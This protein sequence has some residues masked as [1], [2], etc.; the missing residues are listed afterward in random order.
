MHSIPADT[1]VLIPIRSFDDSKSRLTDALDLAQRGALSV[2]MAGRVVAAAG[3]LPVRIVTDDPGVVE[4]AQRRR[5]GVLTV[6]VRGLNASVTAA[7]ARAASLGFERAI[8]AHA[9]L[10]AAVD[11]SVVDR[12]GVCIAPDRARDGSNV[13]CIPTAAGFEFAYGPGSF[14]RHCAEAERLGLT[15][16]VV[17]DDTLAWDVDE[18]ADIPD[19]WPPITPGAELLWKEGG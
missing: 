18:P 8:V 4:W 9:D 13:V 14:G 1:V 10:P 7:V 12:P 15:L 2:W 19:D 16:T 11:L 17:D 5:T 6:D 3:D